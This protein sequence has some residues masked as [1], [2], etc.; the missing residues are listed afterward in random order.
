VHPEQI[1][2]RIYC[3]NEIFILAIKRSLSMPIQSQR[4]AFPGS[5]SATMPLQFRDSAI[6]KENTVKNLNPET[7]PALQFKT[8]K[9]GE[10]EIDTGTI[11][12]VDPCRI[13]EVDLDLL[14]DEGGQIYGK[15]YPDGRK[16]KIAIISSTGIGDGRYP[17]YARTVTDPKLGRQVV[18]LVIHFFP[19]YCFADDPKVANEIAESEK[20]F[21][22]YENEPDVANLK[23]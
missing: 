20:E 12:M 5:I 7:P 9:V 21:L 6:Q 11:V 22:E 2:N 1:P 16:R 4:Q 14:D 19:H 18:E 10:I 8:E 15:Q 13:D 3:K 17:V 23:K